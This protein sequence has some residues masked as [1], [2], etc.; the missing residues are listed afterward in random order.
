MVTNKNQG[1]RDNII[2]YE[3][4]RLL[5]EKGI[6]TT[7]V[8][9]QKEVSYTLPQQIYITLGAFRQDDRDLSIEEVMQFLFQEGAFPRVVDIA[10]R[11]IKN[12]RTLIWI[13]PSDHPYVTTLVETWNTPPGMGPFKSLG[14]MLPYSIWKRPRPLSYQDML[15]AGKE[16]KM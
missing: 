7:L 13:R 14:L 1:N 10:V 3:A 8:E 16:G 15:E 6:T 11:G 5:L 2:T 9:A 12:G 4:L